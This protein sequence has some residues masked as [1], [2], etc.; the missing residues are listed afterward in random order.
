MGRLEH[1]HI[2][3]LLSELPS[4]GRGFTALRQKA[5][6]GAALAQFPTKL[7]VHFPPQASIS[8]GLR[9]LVLL[10]HIACFG[11]DSPLSW[12]SRSA[13]IVCGH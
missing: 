10:E 7:S 8:C 6:L 13:D 12:G 5:F 4:A 3:V 9:D 2:G 11:L 1:A